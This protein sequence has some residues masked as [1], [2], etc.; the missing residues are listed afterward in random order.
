MCD[1]RTPDLYDPLVGRSPSRNCDADSIERMADVEVL[2]SCF[3]RGNHLSQSPPARRAAVGA[4]SN[5]FYSDLQGDSQCSQGSWERHG[6]GRAVASSSPPT[7]PIPDFLLGSQLAGAPLECLNNS[8][9]P[10]TVLAGGLLPAWH[11]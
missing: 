11:P 7:W 8:K 2:D 9:S 3:H 4:H 10:R 6:A 1:R 5:Y